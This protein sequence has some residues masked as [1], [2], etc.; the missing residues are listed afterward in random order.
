M[1]VHNPDKQLKTALERLEDV[2]ILESNK[3]FIKQFVYFLAAEGLVKL[4]QKKYIVILSNIA[5]HL[6]K[7]FTE[8]V[9][10]DI[11]TYVNFFEN[12]EQVNGRPYINWT[13][14]DYKVIIKKFYTWLRN[15]DIDDIDEWYTSSE[16][17][18]I[19][20]KRSKD[21][22]KIPSELLTPEDIELLVA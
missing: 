3:N 14:H 17:K 2:D 5:S 10:K 9:K 12:A 19:K 16:V 1:K 6:D 20:P 4:G 22:N 13:K 18:W 7:K 15:K 8:A 21:S 11:V